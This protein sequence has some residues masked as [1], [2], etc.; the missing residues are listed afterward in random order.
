M[1]SQYNNPTLTGKSILFADD[2]LHWIEGLIEVATAEGCEVLTCRNASRAIQI[3]KSRSIDCIVLDVMMSP[4]SDFPN[5][6]PQKGG[7]VAMEEIFKLKP[8]QSIVCLSVL[9]D[10]NEIDRLKKRNVL[11]LRK[12]E[13]SLKKVWQTIEYKLTGLYRDRSA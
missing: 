5:A 6:D 1:S 9:S 2:E 13:T 4:G 8:R 7:F 11:F 10:Q 12:A 3:V